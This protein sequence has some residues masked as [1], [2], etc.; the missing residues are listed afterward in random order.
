MFLFKS[1][2]IATVYIWLWFQTELVSPP[3]LHLTDDSAAWWEL[4]PPTSD[5]LW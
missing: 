5:P 2:V 4:T 3:S 1:D